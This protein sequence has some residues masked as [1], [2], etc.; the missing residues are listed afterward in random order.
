MQYINM[1]ETYMRYQE[2][3]KQHAKDYYAGNKE[4]IKDMQREKY[5]KLSNEEKKTHFKAK[6]MVYTN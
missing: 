3:A 1:T 5:K 4:K 6:R 2:I